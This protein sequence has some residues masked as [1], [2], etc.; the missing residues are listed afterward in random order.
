MLQVDIETAFSVIPY[1][2]FIG[3]GKYWGKV[4]LNGLAGKY[5]ANAIVNKTIYA[6]II[7]YCNAPEKIECSRPCLTACAVGNSPIRLNLL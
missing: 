2:T 5:L 3:Q 7:I 6:Y 1:S 4:H